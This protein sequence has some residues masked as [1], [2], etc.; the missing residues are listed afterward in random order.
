MR[1][2]TIPVV[3]GLA[4]VSLGGC[5]AT[6]L[7]TIGQGDKPTGLTA[8]EYEYKGADDPLLSSSAAARSGTLSDRFDL[9]QGR[10]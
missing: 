7:S 1:K 5:E 3:L 2:I 4:V 10:E 8:E 9:I 6:G